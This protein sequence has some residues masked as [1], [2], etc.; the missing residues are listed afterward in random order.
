MLGQGEQRVWNRIDNQN[1]EEDQRERKTRKKATEIEEKI[2]QNKM[3]REEGS[4]ENM[5]HTLT[6]G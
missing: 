1:D 5:M 3:R 6:S 2:N 4:I